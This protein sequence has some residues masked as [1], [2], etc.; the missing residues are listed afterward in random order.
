MQ[1]DQINIH[2]IY[3]KRGKQPQKDKTE[4]RKQRDNNYEET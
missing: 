4:H 1:N 3:I 2:K